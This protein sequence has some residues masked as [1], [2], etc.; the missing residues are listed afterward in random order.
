MPTAMQG[1]IVFTE[2][3][4]ADPKRACAFY[5]TLLQ[6]VLVEDNDGPNPVW[7]FPHGAGASPMGHV[8]PGKPAPDGTGMTAHFAVTG[9]LADAMVRV[10]E[11]GGEVVSDVIEIYPGAF[12]YARD[13]EGNSLGIFKYKS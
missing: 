11:G 9:E 8:Y 6:G 13:T 12:F 4:A 7:M 2:I 5:E 1:Q 3:P 10:R